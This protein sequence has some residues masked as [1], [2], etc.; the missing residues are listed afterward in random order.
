M[1]CDLRFVVDEVY[2]TS[3]QLPGQRCLTTCPLFGVHSNL[4]IKLNLKQT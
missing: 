1:D 3:S 4:Y 2:D